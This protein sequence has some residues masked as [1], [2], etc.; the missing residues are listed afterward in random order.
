MGEDRC[1]RVRNVM[2]VVAASRMVPMMAVRGEGRSKSRQRVCDGRE[3]GTGGAG[4]RAG[5]GDGA[6]IADGE[7]VM[8]DFVFIV[9]MAALNCGLKWSEG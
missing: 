6:G 5:A 2:V 8:V 7:I 9:V 4:V 3:A 1:E